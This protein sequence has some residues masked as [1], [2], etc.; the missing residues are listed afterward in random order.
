MP[1]KSIP[2]VFFALAWLCCASLF[3][4]DKSA[5]DRLAIA[6]AQ[7]YN[8]TASGLKSFRCEAAI[9]WKAM[10]TRF[11]GTEISGDN[12]TVKYLQT[13]HLAV[14]D[15]LRGQGSLE[16][17]SPDD[18]PAGEDA[19]VRQ[20]REGLQTAVAGFFQT[21]NAY[22]NGSMV[23]F[24]GKSITVTQSGDGFHV[25]GTAKDMQ[26]DEDFDKNM[27]LTQALVVGPNLRV[28]AIPTFSNT[29]DGLLISAVASRVNQPPSAPEAEVTFRIEYAKVESFQIPDHVVLDIRNIG[30]ID[31]TFSACQ[32]FVAD[33]ARKP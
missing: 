33:W 17:T 10:L 5:R 15:D 9:D 13:V 25:S 24:P 4:Q 30:R 26:I 29:P 7:Y 23:P 12:P 8:P 1:S 14:A 18:P 11:S 32:V 28:L 27:L 3:A 2:L 21:W 16:W 31:F 22:M 6:R 19:S 20:M